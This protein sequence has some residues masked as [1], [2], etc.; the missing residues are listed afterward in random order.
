MTHTT[1]KDA[2]RILLEH[3]EP[4]PEREGLRET[5]SRV[6]KALEFWNKGYK[7]NPKDV[8]KEFDDGAQNYDT[9]VFQGGIQ[10]YSLCE[11]H[12]TPFFGVAHVGYLP[13]G[14]IVGLSK[15]ARL[16][17][18]YSRRLQV[19]ERLTQEIAAALQDNLQTKGVGVVLRC[20]HLCMESRGVQK[21]GTI[22]YTSSLLGVMR[23]AGARDEFL[24]F[25]NMA[26]ARVPHL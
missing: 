1:C 22:T 3:V 21:S 25:V 7:E 13:A 9:M 23:E 14:R 20:R 12:M 11:H 24:H 16:V 2:V 19:Q 10:L 26:D 6:V 17:E 8:L 15:L 4:N 5:P 18:I